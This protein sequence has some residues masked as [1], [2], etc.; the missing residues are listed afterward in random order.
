MSALK[1][2]EDNSDLSNLSI[3]QIELD[4]K[5]KQILELQNKINGLI[6]NENNLLFQP[7]KS[8]D[9]SYINNLPKNIS[10]ENNITQNNLLSLVQ[11]LQKENN[12]L[13]NKLNIEQKIED[14]YTNTVQY[15]LLS[16]K[17]EIEKLTQM[18]ANKDNIINN[19]QNFVNNI[20][21]IISS[22]KINLDLNQIDIRT[23][24]TNLKELEQ[25]IVSKLQNITIYK[26]ISNSKIKKGKNS[27]LKKQ[28]TDLGINI[29]KK[30]YRIP[31]NQKKNNNIKLNVKLS[32]NRNTFNNNSLNKRDLMSL[33]YNNNKNN[34]CK[35]IRCT[36]CRNKSKRNEQFYK[37][38]KQLRLK[39]FLLSKP[40]GVYSRTPK[41]EHMKSLE[42][43]YYDDYLK[44]I[45]NGLAYSGLINED[46]NSIFYKN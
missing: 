36:T 38:R 44:S 37:E 18:N 11:M 3:F 20:N 7:E 13:K 30:F 28:K 40:E 21:K 8:E 10:S 42:G 27:A 45:N 9:Q 43:K 17:I 33:N 2:L 5:N 46:D 14:K 15:K 4:K 31:L 29:R 6:Q 19:L 39:G 41:K 34:E 24:I 35:D 32:S 12:L 16:A 25:K 22:G 23:Y 26:K 1:S